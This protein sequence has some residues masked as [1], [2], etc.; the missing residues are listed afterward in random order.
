MVH[1]TRVPIRTWVMVFVAMASSRNGVSACEIERK[2]HL[3]PRS[4]WS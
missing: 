1:R 2:Y 4:A 3:G